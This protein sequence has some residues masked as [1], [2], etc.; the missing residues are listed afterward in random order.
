MWMAGDMPLRVGVSFGVEG[1][2]HRMSREAL[3]ALD[4]YGPQDIRKK[5]RMPEGR[6]RG[7]W[8]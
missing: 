8:L 5:R 4:P 6:A 1:I 2:P 3:T 7:R